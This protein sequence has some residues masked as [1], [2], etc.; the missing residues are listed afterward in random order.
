MSLSLAQWHERFQQQAGWTRDLRANLFR[1]VGLK[2]AKHVLEVGCGTGAVLSRMN[3]KGKLYGIDVDLPRLDFANTLSNHQFSL[4]CGDGRQLP[5]DSGTFDISFCH[6]LLLWVADPSAVLKE[7]VRVTHRNGAVIAFAE[8]DYGGRIDY[9]DDLA[10]LGD[11]QAEALKHQGADTRM[12]RKLAALFSNSG[13]RN[14]QTGV[15]QGHWSQAPDQ[16]S[17]NMEW[18]ILKDDLKN[19]VN[20]AE[21]GSLQKK[22]LEAWRTGKRVL[23]IPTF[24]AFGIVA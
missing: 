22:N 16:D 15:L 10:P 18:N 13:L 9:P 8:P 21:L 19:K 20:S 2:S 23:F 3:T 4:A 24:Y 1:Q 12:G 7:I 6:Y 14:I 11:F 17:I 5:F